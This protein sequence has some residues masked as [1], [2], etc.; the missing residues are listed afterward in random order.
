MNEQLGRCKKVSGQSE[1]L[2]TLIIDTNELIKQ[3]YR[4]LLEFALLVDGFTIGQLSEI[5]GAS[6]QIVHGEIIDMGINLKNRTP[7]WYR[8]YKI[9]RNFFHNNIAH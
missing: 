2:L 1:K 7:E 8:R 6:R 5:F 3:R 9:R 4:K